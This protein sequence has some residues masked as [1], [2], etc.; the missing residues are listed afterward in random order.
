MVITLRFAIP[1]I[2]AAAAVAGCFS[3]FA[4]PP[5]RV[6]TDVRL[7]PAVLY[8]LAPRHAGINTY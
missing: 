4:A 2:L 3:Y 7:Q 6:E 1:A 8:S 5:A